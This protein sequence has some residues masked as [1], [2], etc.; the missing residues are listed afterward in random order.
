MEASAARARPGLSEPAA[1]QLRVRC[2]SHV[3]TLAPRG[4]SEVAVAVL[5]LLRRATCHG[6][7]GEG[8]RGG[9]A[10]RVSVALAALLLGSLVK[11]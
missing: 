11:L 4:R 5:A 3:D 8:E 9:F 2:M 1:G 6:R 10:T 7:A